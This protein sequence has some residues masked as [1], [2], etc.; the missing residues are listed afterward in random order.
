ML[1]L[2]VL[3]LIA[4]TVTFFNGFRLY[5]EYRLVADTPH[6]PIGSAS[7][8]LV[9][10][11]GLAQSIDT[12]LSPVTRTP[13]CFY[14]VDI[15]EWRVSSKGG[16]NFMHLRTAMDGVRFH[17][18]DDSGKIL[19]DLHGA[20][21]ELDKSGT[22]IVDG[23]SDYLSATIADLEAAV[24]GKPPDPYVP[25]SEQELL[26]YVVYC[27]A[28][29][30][31]RWIESSREQAQPSGDSSKE[32]TRLA[33][34]AL[35]REVTP[36]GSTMPEVAL[37]AMQKLLE[38]RVAGGEPHANQILSAFREH[39]NELAA[40]AARPSVLQDA[41][42]KYKLTERC[43]TL[44]T[45]YEIVGT[46]TENPDATGLGDHSMI[47]KG[48]EEST[49]QISRNTAGEVELDLRSRAAKMILGGAAVFGIFL[50]L[51]LELSHL[52]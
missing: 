3:G 42:G 26:Q 43:V 25:P 28:P 8:G 7:M 16:G 17:I 49:F 52:L 21:F 39:A 2:F 13:C 14:C 9:R 10:V 6:I 15:K 37:E 48:R 50:F 46:C 5:R 36:P 29:Q 34:L 51:I 24:S 12:V 19:V 45:P 35:L 30:I 22:R 32:Q 20:T 27:D 44:N 38:A 40:A 11:R 4:G 18:A 33:L 31:T 41:P 23:T 1:I 47:A